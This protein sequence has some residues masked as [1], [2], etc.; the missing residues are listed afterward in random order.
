MRR[1]R[2]R[3]MPVITMVSTVTQS[4]GSSHCKSVLH[5]T[6]SS[7][8]LTH[9]Q[10]ARARPPWRSRYPVVC[11]SSFLSN[12]NL[13][14]EDPTIS[15]SKCVRRVIYVQ[16]IQ[17]YRNTVIMHGKHILGLSGGFSGFRTSKFGSRFAKFRIDRSDRWFPLTDLAES[18][19]AKGLP[20]GPFPKVDL[21][22]TGP[23]SS[24]GHSMTFPFSWTA[25][26]GA[27][28]AAAEVQAAVPRPKLHA[29]TNSP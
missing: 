1:R 8:G 9:S 15:H 16:M 7:S 6:R 19:R 26:F 13:G 12:R 21:G 2:R 10:P 4:C 18:R 27:L 25:F 23:V 28:T 14:R 22:Y 20:F 5:F 17:T 24:P 3:R 29:G 11:I